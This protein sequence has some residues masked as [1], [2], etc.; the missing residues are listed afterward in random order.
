VAKKRDTVQI[1]NP[2]RE[3]DANF[4]SRKRALGY[5]NDG[6]AEWASSARAAIRFIE[7]HRTQK[8]V[9][10]A[11][12]KDLGYDRAAALGL[13]SSSSIA[14]TPVIAPAVLLGVGN[15]TGARG[16]S[17]KMIRGLV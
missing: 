12:M 2:Q 9:K 10:V 5:V 4:T 15:N 1:L 8:S 6:R 11:T 3:C 7:S 13:S 17:F 16:S 14:N